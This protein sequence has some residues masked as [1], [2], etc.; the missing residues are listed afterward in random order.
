MMFM[1]YSEDHAENVF[2]MFNSETS[3][4]AQSRDVIWLGKMYHTR[5]GADF[6]QQLPIVTVPISIQDAYVDAEIQKLEVAT[7]PFSE[8]RGIEHNSSSVKA[9]E[10]MVAKTRYGCAIG[11]KDGS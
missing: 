11:R 7:F 8:E 10:W 1:G 9:D 5:R 3:R 4:I 6:T 2:Q